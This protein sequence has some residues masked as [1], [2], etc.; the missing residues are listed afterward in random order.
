MASVLI[1][2]DEPL[3]RRSVRDLLASRRPA[4]ELLVAGDGREALEILSRREVDLV[5]T[6]VRMPEIDGVALV[7]RLSARPRWIPVIVI[8]AH[9]TPTLRD[10]VLGGGALRF[11]E[12]P[13]DVDELLRALDDLLVDGAGH[14]A[15]VTAAGVA[16]LVALEGKTCRLR[17]R[18]VRGEVHASLFFEAGTLVDAQ[19]ESLVGA[20]AALQ[21]LA[22]GS[23]V[24]DV[25]PLGQHRGSVHLPLHHLM[26]E[27]A[28]LADEAGRD[29]DALDGPLE[30]DE[31]AFD[32]AF[33]AVSS[34]PPRPPSDRATS[35]VVPA[36]PRA[37]IVSPATP[38]SPTTRAAVASGI[39]ASGVITSTSSASAADPSTPS[40]S[41]VG[42]MPKTQPQET[43]MANINDSL[44]AIMDIEGGIAA[45]LV[46][47]ESGLTLG[48]IGG[49]RFDIE[50]AA[51]GNTTVVKAKMQVMRQ[52]GLKGHIEDI[53]ITL[54]DQFHL[55]RPLSKSPSLFLYVAI[56]KKKGNLGLARHKLKSV[57]ENLVL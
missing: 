43:E 33:A 18:P 32:R 8:T 11:L 50:L 31:H 40:A 27:A 37:P 1:V 13:L 56:D 6:D 51:S 54:D 53:L 7:G 28:R 30:L 38:V 20:D 25:G 19:Y 48:T 57:E 21:I 16:Q 41:T 5:L 15:G 46:D 17:L 23:C 45:A 9:G 29:V 4:L 36:S 2:D 10:R 42:R 55:I 24:V 44:N 14:L 22:W 39:A 26:I 52:L 12:K 35:P 47:W 3:F 34:L 49:G